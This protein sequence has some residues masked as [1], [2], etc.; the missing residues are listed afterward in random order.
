MSLIFPIAVIFG[1]GCMVITIAIGFVQDT[2]EKE[3]TPV[4]DWLLMICIEVILISA[5]ALISYS[6]RQS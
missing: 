6:L 1:L 4:V 3:D 5:I 2:L